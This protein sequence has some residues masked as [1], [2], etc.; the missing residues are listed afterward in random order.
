[1][2]VSC[3][4]PATES[5]SS[6]LSELCTVLPADTLDRTCCGVLSAAFTDSVVVA[7]AMCLLSGAAGGGK[8]EATKVAEDR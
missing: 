6:R 7:V 1:M 8:A 2:S 4:T 5:V 3:T